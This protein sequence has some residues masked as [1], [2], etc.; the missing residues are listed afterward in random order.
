MPKEKKNPFRSGSKLALIFDVLAKSRI[1]LPAEEVAKRSK[2]PI[3]TV[4]NMLSAMLNPFHNA[5][6]RRTASR[7]ALSGGKYDLVEAKPEPEAKRKARGIRKKEKKRKIQRTS[8]RPKPR[9]KAKS[10]TKTK[11]SGGK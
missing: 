6:L 5:P 2:I 1:P 9:R 4:R 7:V 10:K 11:K 3:S 8:G